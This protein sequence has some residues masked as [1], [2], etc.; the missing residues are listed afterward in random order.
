MQQVFVT[1][2]LRSGTSLLQILLTNHPRLFI[3]YQPFH[4]LYVDAKQMFLDEQGWKRLLPLG[5]GTDA[6]TDEPEKLS[7]WLASRALDADEIA[8]LSSRAVTGKGG[9]AADFI[10]STLPE[11]ATFLTLREYLHERLAEQSAKAEIEY[12][13]AKEV[14]CEEYVPALAG[15]GVRCF[16]IARDPRAVVASANHGHY[17]ELVGDR[18]PLLMLIR[19]WRKSA[20]AWLAM[21]SHPN[22]T[23]LRYEDLTVETDSIL[24]AIA[25]SLSI[26]PFPS[27]LL[28]SPL[29]D[30]RGAPWRGNSSFGD[31]PT[32]SAASEEAWRTLL[33]DSEARFIE[34]CAQAEMAA[35]GYV[36]ALPAERNAILGFVENTDGVRPGYLKHY[37]L[38]TR[39][40]EVELKRWDMHFD[41]ATISQ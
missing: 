23:V 22:V 11:R 18:Y 39:N 10:P 14:L 16:I 29:L 32:I 25:E 36:P 9:G 24:D 4:Q 13:G 38:D 28:R 17:R 6:A 8:R 7:E 12:A 35:L 40:R 41:N 27:D 34:A 15:A 19:L 37:A 21:A 5:D 33:S 1:G 26:G 30:H 31:K 2:M 20:R 3:A